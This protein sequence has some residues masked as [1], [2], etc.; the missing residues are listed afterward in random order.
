MHHIPLSYQAFGDFPRREEGPKIQYMLATSPR[1]G[2]T[3]V[4]LLLWRSGVLGAP[5]EYLNFDN[6]NGIVDRL[7][8]GCI[9]SYWEEVR[10]VRAS[11]NG[12]FG[13]KIFFGNYASTLKREPMLLEQIS[14][15]FAI[16]LRRRDKIAQAISHFRAMQTQSWFAGVPE[17]VAPSYDFKGLLNYYRHAH[18]QDEKWERVF[19]LT[20]TDPLRLFY[21]DIMGDPQ[22][23]LSAICSFLGV[24]ANPDAQIERIAL[25]KP[26]RDSMT[27]DWMG[28]FK[29]DLEASDGEVG[30]DAAPL[31]LAV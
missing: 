18:R 23:A 28:R 24:E 21:E 17:R 5:M 4:A 1:C 25:T 3:Y 2:S 13:Y 29:A 9:S 22:G 26:Q 20:Q 6:I 27:E 7:G 19:S 30:A 8:N 16:F 11:P 14:A 10:R 15:N 31:T 12:V